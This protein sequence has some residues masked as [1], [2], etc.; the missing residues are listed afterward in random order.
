MAATR[1]WPKHSARVPTACSTEIETARLKGRGG[2]AFPTAV[3]WRGVR[4]AAGERK[5]IVVNADESEPGTFKDRHLMELDPFAIVEAATIAG[6]VTGAQKGFVYIRG[7][8]PLAT[9]RLQNAID[10]ARSA[11]FLGE[12]IARSSIAFDLEIRRG[13]GAYIC[14]EETALFESLEGYRGEPRQKPPFPT[15]HGLFHEP[16]VINN[17]ETLVNVLEILQRGGAE[18]ATTGTA[19][20]TGSRLFCLSGHV[21]VPGLYEVPFGVTLGALIEMAGGADR[22]ASG[23]SARRRR[24]QFRRPGVVVDAAHLRGQLAPPGPRSGRV[25]SCCSTPPPTSPRSSTASPSSSATRVAG[26]AFRAGWAWSASTNFFSGP[27]GVR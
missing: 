9:Q 12:R 25:W 4:A 19:D 15:T 27:P 11:G 13:A 21:Q 17:P 18:F 7:E 3:K 8:Y 6:F 16:T 26:S 1:R 2:A 5:W 22:R 10:A 14:G 23:G 20:S 24:R